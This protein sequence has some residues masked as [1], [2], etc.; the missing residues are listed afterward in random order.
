M[1]SPPFSIETRKILKI[2]IFNYLY[3]NFCTLSKMIEPDELFLSADRPLQIFQLQ[4]TNI[5]R[6]DSRQIKLSQKNI[7]V[8]ELSNQMTNYYSA[9]NTLDGLSRDKSF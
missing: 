3:Q 9:N 6:I 1:L 4:L 8:N 5:L 2:L 7:L